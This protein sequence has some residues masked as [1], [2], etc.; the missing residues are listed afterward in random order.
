MA[1]DT[2]SKNILIHSGVHWF[3][4]G[5][6]TPSDSLIFTEMK[7][8][9]K[10][11]L[12]HIIFFQIIITYYIFVNRLEEKSFHCIL[13]VN[14]F[15]NKFKQKWLVTSHPIY[16]PYRSLRYMGKHRQYPAMIL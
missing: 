4:N 8:R 13:R 3:S 5:F 12:S 1:T 15:F 14:I 2:Y 7:V 6:N 10:L 9:R 11:Y 16:I